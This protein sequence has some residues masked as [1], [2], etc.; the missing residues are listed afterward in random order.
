MQHSGT[1]QLD[2]DW[3]AS[4]LDVL[5]YVPTSELHCNAFV[6]V[7]GFFLIEKQNTFL[8]EGLIIW[9]MEVKLKNRLIITVAGVCYPPSASFYIH[10]VQEKLLTSLQKHFPDEIYTKIG[11]K[12]FLRNMYDSSETVCIPKTK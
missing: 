12:S 5:S 6:K 11:E 10:I 8:M 2:G 7:Q 9:N 1:N 4:S 3:A